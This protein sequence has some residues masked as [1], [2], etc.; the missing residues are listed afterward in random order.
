VSAATPTPARAVVLLSGGLDSS[1]L[2]HHVVRQ[3]GVPEVH[4]ISFD[5]GQRHAVE[6]ECAAW[7]AAAVAVR[8]TVIP[9]GFLGPMLAAG[10]TLLAAGAP[11]PDLAD[12]S[13]AQLSQPP[14]Y[15]P[16]RNLLLLSLSA[17]YAEAHDISDVYYG[18]QA[19]DEYG[20]WD[21]TE[22]FL[23]RMN[24]VLSLNR[25]TPVT[26]HAPFVA[27]DK[28]ANVKLGV[29]LGVDFAH[30]WTCYRGGEGQETPQP[31]GTC[32]SCVER[33]QAFAR[34]GIQDPLRYLA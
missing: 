19:Q 5:Y 6:L 4:A 27:H 29:A 31:C 9:M 12:L 26:I 17:A 22:E 30:T 25:D 20:Y 28:A 34:A 13:A 10:S 8:H 16:H 23:A 2:L 21:C 18:A 32:P 11:V 3:L 24:A 7:Q 1:V 14:T 33:L 15:V